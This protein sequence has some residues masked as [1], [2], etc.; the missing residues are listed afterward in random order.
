MSVNVA[1]QKKA[2]RNKLKYEMVAYKRSHFY[3]HHLA[4]ERK[5][6]ISSPKG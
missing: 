4:K 3:P 5:N 6:E 2:N 1:R